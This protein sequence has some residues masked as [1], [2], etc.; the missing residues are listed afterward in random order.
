[1]PP[2]GGG[3]RKRDHGV[4]IHA[5]GEAAYTSAPAPLSYFL[6]LSM[7]SPASFFA[8]ASY[9]V[10]SFQVSRGHRISDGTPGQAVTTSKP[11]TGSRRVFADASAPP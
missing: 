2:N 6:K 11:N 3:K 4:V 7:N 5:A 10:L 8:E 9:V 1:M